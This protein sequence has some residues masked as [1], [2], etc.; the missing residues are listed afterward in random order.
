MPQAIVRQFS[1]CPPVDR[2]RRATHGSVESLSS[3]GECSLD[4]DPRPSGTT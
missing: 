2:I 4:D 3:F 1:A